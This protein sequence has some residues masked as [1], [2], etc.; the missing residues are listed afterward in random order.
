MSVLTTTPLKVAP[1]AAAGVTV[2]IGTMPAWG[3]WVQ[4]LAA[5]AAPTA[6]AGVQLAGGS[7]PQMIVRLGRTSQTT[8]SV[9]RPVREVLL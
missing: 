9:R 4:V 6:I 7:Y 8:S 3:A 1:S 2:T 5:T